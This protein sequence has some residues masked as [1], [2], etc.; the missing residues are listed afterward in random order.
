[1]TGYGTMES[2]CLCIVLLSRRNSRD[3]LSTA[4]DMA[5]FQLGPSGYEDLE[6]ET[7]CMAV[8]IIWPTGLGSCSLNTFQT[9]S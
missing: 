7:C 9:W 2:L 1:M 6:P 5:K 8:A 4:L 3:I